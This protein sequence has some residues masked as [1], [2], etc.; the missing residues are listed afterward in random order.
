MLQKASFPSG[1]DGKESACNRRP[2]FHPWVRKIPWRREWQPT[3]V[4]LPGKL[5]GQRRLTGKSMGWQRVGHGRA[6]NTALQTN[7][8]EKFSDG[9]EDVGVKRV[10]NKKD[11]K[12]KITEYLLGKIC[13]TGLPKGN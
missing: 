9:L 13:I 3:S 7:Y 12:R 8:L 2:G 5:H 1:S 4:F 10:N 11:K 6:T